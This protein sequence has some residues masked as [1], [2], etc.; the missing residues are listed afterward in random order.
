MVFRGNQALRVLLL[1]GVATFY[2]GA[3][4]AQNQTTTDPAAVAS[5]RAQLEADLQNLES[6]IE[7]LRQT[8]LHLQGERASLERDVTLLDA[9]I[10]QAQLAIRMRALTINKLEAQIT[11]KVGIIGALG[12]KYEREKESLA[13]MIRQ[14]DELS[15]V[16]EVE[17]VL[18]YKNL[19]EYFA[20]VDSLDYVQKGIQGSFDEIKATK[21]QTEDEKAAL[22]D[23]K[24]E[25]SDLREIQLL[26]KRRIEEREKEKK[27]ILKVTQGKEKEYQNI[28]NNR[29]KDAAKIRAELFVLRDSA[30]IPFGKAVEFATRAGA[31]TGIRAALILGIITQESNLGENTGQCFV[32]DL[33]TGSGVGKNTDR[34]FATVMKAPRDTEPFVVIAQNIGFDPLNTAVSCPPSYGY[35]GAM[36]PA[37]FIPSTWVLYEEKIRSLMGGKILNPWEAEDA[38]MA[39][40]VLL[41]E[42]GAGAGTYFAER[43]AALRYFAGWKNANKR[44]YAFYGD[45]VMALASKYQGQIDIL[46]GK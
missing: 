7:D 6:Q 23:R 21:Q 31:K 30:A 44:A 37:Q 33:R 13:E 18:Q 19:A 26:E 45:D 14:L 5:H 46:S 28:L 43:L 41:K 39:S 16:S 20:R 12:D 27:Q 4:F 34:Y 29:E 10:K 3:V 25:E 15:D 1:L 24:Q 38:F 17:I 40:A 2:A 9:Q 36:G 35:G 32:K 42:N 22:E 8:T 11:E